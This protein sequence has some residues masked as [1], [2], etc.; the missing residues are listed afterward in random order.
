MRRVQPTTP[1]RPFPKEEVEQS[2]PARFESIVRRYPERLAVKT[3]HHSCTYDELNRAANR[4]AHA[5]LAAHGSNP[6]PVV[7]LIEQ[8]VQAFAAMLGV[9][10]AGKFYVPLHPSLPRA[11][12]VTILQDVQ[13]GLLITTQQQSAAAKALAEN[14]CQILP[15]ETLMTSHITENPGLVLPPDTC[16]EIVYTSGSTG[17]PKGVVWN[18]RNALHDCM[19]TAHGMHL[20]AD[21]RIT[22][23]AAWDTAQAKTTIYRA[24]LTGASLYPW[25][26]KQEGLTHL[27]AWLI[28]EAITVYYSSATIFRAFIDSLTGQETF[29]HMRVVRVG[30]E[31]AS[32]QDV[33]AY[34]AHFAPHC[35]FLNSLSSTETATSRMYLIDKHTPIRDQKVPVGYA[36]DD[37]DVVLWDEHNAE[38][39]VN[40]PG[41]IVVKSRYLASGYWRRP[42]LTAATFLPDPA[43]GDA[44]LYRTG[45]LGVMRPDSCLIHLGRKDFRVKIRGYSIE[46]PE[47]EHVL[48]GHTGLKDVAVMARPDHTG[49]QHLVAYVVPTQEPGPS[50]AVLQDFVHQQLPDYM[51]PAMFVRLDA[52]PLTASGKVDR[53]RLPAPRRARPSLASAYVVPRTP[54][55][56]TLVHIWAE[57]L[58]FEQIG[59]HDHFL[60]LGGDSLLATR[61]IARVCETFQVAIPQRQLMETPT[62]AHMAE[63]IVE[64]QATRLGHDEMLRL[65][66][67]VKGS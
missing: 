30:G 67:E 51:V 36:V 27:A 14:G 63:I 45:D 6:E 59:V 41:E 2:I 58:G 46:L 19:R 10:K 25:H 11:R 16:A 57:V 62:I 61:I 54:V 15:I 33:E 56:A 40:Q 7:L 31:A 29:P 43:G 9:L 60:M 39:G 53:Q 17:Q 3:R 44:R 13:P 28:E 49:E 20:N 42:D 5:I 66:A 32:A 55:E 23:L 38:V 22:L 21:D 35:L 8:S 37:V 24:L 12:L 48:R 65:L 18:H 1:F 50:I 26:V 34:K 4:V 52:L 47:V 64:Y